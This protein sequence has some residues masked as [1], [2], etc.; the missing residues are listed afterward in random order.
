MTKRGKN[1]A[2]FKKFDGAIYNCM[3]LAISMKL[4]IWILLMIIMVGIGAHKSFSQGSFFSKN[5]RHYYDL[6]AELR[7]NYKVINFKDTTLLF[8]KLTINEDRTRIQD[9]ITLYGY[10]NGYAEEIKLAPDTVDLFQF[11]EFTDLNSHYF[12]FDISNSAHKKLLV[13][14]ILN[15]VTGNDFYFDINVDPE[16]KTTNSGI[17]MKR[18]ERPYPFFRNYMNTNE[19]FDLVNLKTADS[20]L[21]IYTYGSDFKVADPPFIQSGSTVIKSL[22]IDSLFSVQSRAHITIPN[23]GLYF[24]QYDTTGVNGLAFR[25]ENKPFPKQGTYED[26]V[27]SLT[28]FTTRSEMVKLL[29]NPDK[30]KAFDSY[31]IE[32]TKSSERARKVIKEYYKRV[33][34]ANSIFTTYKQGW[35][36]DKG[37]IY[38]IYGP[39]DEV[40]R[41]GSRE[42]WIYERTN[43]LPRINFTFIKARSIFTNDHYVLLR[44]E[45]YQQVWYKAIDLWRKGQKEL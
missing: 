26:L 8:L 14:K 16:Q 3:L 18:P 32:V 30:K 34:L 33:L 25:I 36:T 31:W 12:K 5:L 28:Y 29:D 40:L 19:R 24:T 7:M 2:I 13:I 17:V 20:T 10:L 44:R 38:I 41:D 23:P 21:F 43:Q 45:S 9:L 39:P 6:D 15:K 1:N 22:S 42:E 35:K 11:R 4:R 37:M 27:K